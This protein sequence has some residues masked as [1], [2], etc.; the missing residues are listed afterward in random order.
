MIHTDT[1]THRQLILSTPAKRRVIGEGERRSTH[2]GIVR[3]N[4]A[5]GRSA[6]SFFRR[7]YTIDLAEKRRIHRLP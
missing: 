3:R 6:G 4:L 5:V 1:L 2:H 7:P